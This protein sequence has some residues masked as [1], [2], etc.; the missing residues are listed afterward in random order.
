[1]D[2]PLQQDHW[3]EETGILWDITIGREE[4]FSFMTI[5]DILE[6]NARQR[7]EIKWLNDI[8]TNNIS[9]LAAQIAQ[10]NKA[11][12]SNNEAIATNNQAIQNNADQVGLVSGRVTTNEALIQAVNN[13]VNDN[14]GSIEANSD[15]IGIVKERATSNEAHIAQNKL[16][17][18]ENQANINVVDLKVDALDVKVKED[19]AL[20]DSLVVKIEELHE[21]PLGSITAW[22][23]RPSS[24][25]REASLPDG[26]Q[27]CD[28]S[29]ISAPSIWEGKVTPNLNGERRFLRGGSDADMLKLEEDQLQEHTHKV[30]DPGHNHQFTDRYTVNNGEHDGPED[31]NGLFG[32]PHSAETAIG[33]TGISV[34][35]V[36][37]T[38]R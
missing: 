6:E 1:M 27:K 7:A 8:I 12:S 2:D 26:W 28:G 20:L 10:N 31:G 19:E 38:F 4:P 21:A 29:I 37:N 33:S 22:V 25:G 32:Y 14:V 15:L 17:I 30:N 11:I 24:G 35:V 13:R 18:D 34:D 36:E 9:Q 5:D 16:R 3:Q 23:T